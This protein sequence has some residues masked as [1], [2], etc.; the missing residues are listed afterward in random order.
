MST[1]DPQAD[2]RD[3]LE[4]LKTACLTYDAG[5]LGEALQLA[6]SLRPL[7]HDHGHAVS[8][9]SRLRAK[10]TSLLSTLAKQPPDYKGG[11]WP[12]LV[13]WDLDPV[14]SVFVCHPWLDATRRVQRQVAFE[15]WWSGEAIYQ[16]GPRKIRRRDLILTVA[17]SA[18]DTHP[19]DRPPVDYS[20]LFAPSEWRV[21]IRPA[22]G[23]DRE[24]HL[25]HAA[26]AS[27]RQIAFEVL[28]SSKLLELAGKP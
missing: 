24:I 6:R 23:A 15:S 7:F 19:D 2:L 14:N 9:L 1:A 20:W 26:Q 5:D 12:G 16:H 4:V 10:H 22:N 18:G 13:R 27:V 3:Q 25:H 17:A 11:S 8:L 21:T 28:N